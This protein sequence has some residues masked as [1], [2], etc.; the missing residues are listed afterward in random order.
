MCSNPKGVGASGHRFQ[1]SLEV[2]SVDGTKKQQDKPETYVLISFPNQSA[3]GVPTFAI[4]SAVHSLFLNAP[5]HT[6]LV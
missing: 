4:V 2:K 6:T 1:L 5:F 3:C